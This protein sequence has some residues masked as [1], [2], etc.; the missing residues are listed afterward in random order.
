VKLDLTFWSMFATVAF[1][2]VGIFFGIRSR[3]FKRLVGEYEALT[4][5]AKAHPDI[6]I[7]F[8]GTEVT[9]LTRTV[10]VC[11]NNGSEPIRSADVPLK[12][13]VL[14][15]LPDRCRILS[16][17]IL[18]SSG[19]ANDVTMIQRS[20]TA[21]EL[22]F[23]FL[24]HNDGAVVEMLYE[25]ATISAPSVPALSAAIIGGRTSTFQRH[26]WTRKGGDSY[27]NLAIAASFVGCGLAFL[28]KGSFGN[29]RPPDVVLALVGG[30][31]C[32]ALG[33]I[34]VNANLRN[35]LRPRVPGFAHPW[36]G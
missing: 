29:L 10:V 13:P 17:S 19:A 22:T 4:L 18:A 33:G 32:A 35:L 6:S 8:R 28:W 9:F 12:S 26:S 11:W 25:S 7:R 20:E 23:A 34:G 1:G 36:F 27:F 14:L 3:R 5:Q 30:A 2:L 21:L 24:N 31:F 16:A 15:T